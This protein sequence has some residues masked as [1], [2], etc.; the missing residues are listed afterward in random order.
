[1]HETHGDSRDGARSDMDILRLEVVLMEAVG[2]TTAVGVAD[3]TA[4]AS[5]PPGGETN[6]LA[7][8]AAAAA[9][10]AAVIAPPAIMATGGT[11]PIEEG[12]VVSTATGSGTAAVW[13]RS[14]SVAAGGSGTAGPLAGGTTIGLLTLSIGLML[15]KLPVGVMVGVVPIAVN[16]DNSDGGSTFGTSMPR[17]FRFISLQA[18]LNSLMSILPSES[19]SAKALQTAQ[20]HRTDVFDVKSRHGMSPG[21]LTISDPR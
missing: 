2:E 13:A 14:A 11:A 6:L 9:G 16:E 21:S 17:S 20:P 3:M 12:C 4:A 1:M 15:A 7:A 10:T 19:V 18:M 5:M 8:A